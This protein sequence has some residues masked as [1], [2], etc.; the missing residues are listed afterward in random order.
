MDAKKGARLMS[1]FSAKK[2]GNMNKFDST[3]VP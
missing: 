1:R 3:R 2:D